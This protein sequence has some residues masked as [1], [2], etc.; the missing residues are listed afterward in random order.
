ML[1]VV[2]V[3]RCCPSNAPSHR[4]LNVLFLEC[5]GACTG[6]QIVDDKSI[7]LM[8]KYATH[9]ALSYSFIICTEGSTSLQDNRKASFSKECYTLD[10]IRI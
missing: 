7:Y 1:V 6:R 10:F 8:Q 2:C 5:Y 3:V 9:A 4:F